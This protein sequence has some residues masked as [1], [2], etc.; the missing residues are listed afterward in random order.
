V[1]EAV[2]AGVRHRHLERSGQS[3]CNGAVARQPR[4]A[5][6]RYRE[7]VVA[8][9][10]SRRRCASG[11]SR[12]LHLRA[13]S[14]DDLQRRDLKFSKRAA[15]GRPL[16]RPSGC[17]QPFPFLARLRPKEHR[18]TASSNLPNAQPGAPALSSYLCRPAQ[19]SL[20]WDPGPRAT[21]PIRLAA[22]LQWCRCRRHKGG[23]KKQR[24]ITLTKG[25]YL[26]NHYLH[27]RQP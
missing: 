2:A 12:R 19:T 26:H 23:S 24:I 8:A 9:N 10:A 6:G 11:R 15:N 5:A 18:V 16:P 25:N 3:D 14:V 20:K 27:L 7:R 4:L 13:V 22:L 17:R 1:E 21:R